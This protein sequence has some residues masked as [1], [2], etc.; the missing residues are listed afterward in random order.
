[1]ALASSERGEHLDGAACGEYDGSVVTASNRCIVHEI[2]ATGE[3][4]AESVAVARSRSYENIGQGVAVV[5]FLGRASSITRG[6][7]IADGS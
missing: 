6:R 4:I 5:R 7:P 2:R 3:H 1:L